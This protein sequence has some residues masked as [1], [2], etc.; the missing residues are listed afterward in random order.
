M[1]LGDSA[2]VEVGFEY[3]D[4]TGLD[5]T[6]RNTAWRATPL[7]ERTTPGEFGYALEGLASGHT[8]DV[9]ALV[10]HPLLTLYGAEVQAKVP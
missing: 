7:T 3:R 6:E 5:L 4:A 2:S 8:Y 9:R 1:K 10:K